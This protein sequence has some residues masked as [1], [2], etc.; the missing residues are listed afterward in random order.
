MRIK[1]KSPLK[2][3]TKS[4]A[5]RGEE[6]E[7]RLS[8]KI[9]ACTQNRELSWLKF[10]E[11]VLEEADSPGNP[12]LERLKFLAIF[13][14]NLDE[15]YMIRVG[16]LTDY[17]QF[18]PDYFDNKT[19]MTAADQLAIIFRRSAALYEMRDQSYKNLVGLLA[20]SNIHM[21]GVSALPVQER[22][23]LRKDFKRAI[24]PLLSPQVIDTHH[25]FPN[26]ENKQLYIAVTLKRKHGFSYGIMAIPRAMNRLIQLGGDQENRFVLLEDAALTFA[27]EAF[28]TYEVLERTVISV[29][30]NADLALHEDKDEDLDYVAHMKKELKKRRRLAPVRLEMQSAVGDKFAA[31]LAERLDIRAE[32]AFVCAAPLDLSFGYQLADLPPID[33]NLLWP[34]HTPSNAAFSDRS[35]DMLVRARKGDILLSYPYESIIPFLTMIKQ[36][37]NDDSVLSIKITLYRIDRYSKLA[38]SLIEAAEN[39]KDVVVMMELR[40]RFDENNNIDWAQRLE[41]SGCRVLYGLA[42]YKVHSK[43]C[44]ITCQDAGGIRYITQVGTGNY[45]EKT[46]KLYT[47]LSLITA[48]AEIGADAAAFFNDMQI[49]NTDGAYK[50]LWVAP[51]TLKTNLTR[52][53]DRERMKA[54]AGQPGRIVIK[55]NSI[56]DLGICEALAAASQSGVKIDLIVR[57]I[58]C[59][60]PG[61]AGLTQNMTVVSI[62]GRFL[63]HSRV[64]C[65]GDGPD[66]ALY[67]ASADLMTRNMHRRVEIAC[68]VLDMRLRER[69]CGMLDIM[70]RDNVKAREQSADGRYEPRTPDS[71]VPI[72][73]QEYFAEQA[74]VLI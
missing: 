46:A 60:L 32:Q 23:A 1:T 4:K 71:G 57:G 18:M 52:M 14:S 3:V 74:R 43:I 34:R 9:S 16:S 41:E 39:G 20:E 25:P 35:E 36:A 13:T 72:S 31:F 6:R 45:N 70:L 47:D 29:T 42:D 38:E 33:R 28:Q 27:D 24:L 44:L 54:A 26:L 58:C 69:I 62:V 48:D 53:I 55:C 30:R 22:K 21:L 61:V 73:A 66:M 7:C 64:F 37:A 40:A 59:V 12:L 19:G 63:E 17:M 10:N 51:S 68:P 67:I 2:I 11:R 15:F 65:F 50:R 5:D 56:T 8:P 49:N